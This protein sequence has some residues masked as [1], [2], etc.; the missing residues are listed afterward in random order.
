M[1]DLPEVNL[2]ELANAEPIVQSAKEQTYILDEML[3]TKRK[4]LANSSAQFFFD[5]EDE[6]MGNE[7]GGGIN[8][9][10]S[11][12]SVRSLIPEDPCTSSGFSRQQENETNELDKYL[13]TENSQKL[14]NNVKSA[15]LSKEQLNKFGR[16]ASTASLSNNS[17]LL[18]KGSSSRED[19]ELSVMGEN[20][21]LIEGEIL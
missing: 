18:G 11:S 8:D 15:E 19:D 7:G 9:P 20:E 16:P 12:D 21:V 14:I 3:R 4:G 1:D 6:S 2:T 17:E 10:Q 5:E 13:I